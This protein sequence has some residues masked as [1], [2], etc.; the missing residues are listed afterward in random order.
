MWVI[1]ITRFYSSCNPILY[2]LRWPRKQ[3][4][5]KI[6]RR[7]NHRLKYYLRLCWG[8][9]YINGYLSVRKTNGYYYYSETKTRPY[10]SDHLYWY[11][12]RH[13]YWCFYWKWFYRSAILFWM[14]KRRRNFSK[15]S[16]EFFNKWTRK[17]YTH[18]YQ[19]IHLWLY[20]WQH[21][22]YGYWI[23]ETS[24]RNLFNQRM[25]HR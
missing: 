22:F 14:E 3:Q 5:R 13:H 7:S 20:L 11:W 19:L 23:F 12:Y 9:H 10:S 6:P 17:L 21:P 2:K 15:Y 4:H 18:S 16:R 25:V 8:W 1:R 24:F